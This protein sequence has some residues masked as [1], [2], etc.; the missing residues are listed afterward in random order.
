MER[1]WKE[2]LLVTVKNIAADS[3]RIICY[4]MS[5]AIFFLLVKQWSSC[6][7]E[8]TA[9]TFPS[10]FFHSTANI[11]CILILVIWLAVERRIW[12]K[13]CGARWMYGF[14]GGAADYFSSLSCCRD[15]DCWTVHPGAV[16]LWPFPRVKNKESEALMKRSYKNC[17]W[18]W[19]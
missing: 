17:S 6:N 5:T 14:N 13:E 12:R 8:S 11:F 19:R 9:H 7:R 16:F 18:R 4:M 3:L 10:P 15:K 2:L 1:T